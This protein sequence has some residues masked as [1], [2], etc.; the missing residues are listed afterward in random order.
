LELKFVLKQNVTNTR[1][2]A[3]VVVAGQFFGKAEFQE[4]LDK[5]AA[6]A[7]SR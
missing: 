7:G 5:M 6:E 2:I 4:M 1:R 3:A